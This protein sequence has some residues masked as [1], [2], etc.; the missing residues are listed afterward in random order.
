MVSISLYWRFNICLAHCIEKH[1]G[2]KENLGWI[3][4]REVIWTF[5]T[6]DDF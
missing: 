4:R 6:N 1:L 5:G 3:D 2:V